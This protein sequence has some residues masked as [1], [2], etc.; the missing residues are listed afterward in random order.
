MKITSLYFVTKYSVLK[1][2]WLI[3]VV[4]CMS[5]YFVDVGGLLARQHKLKDQY[6]ILCLT[7]IL[8]LSD[9]GVPTINKGVRQGCSLLPTLFNICI[10]DMFETWE[11]MA[12]PGIQMTNTS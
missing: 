10:D 3:V 12:Y 8:G 7:I 1:S 6:I 9:K 5:K 11:T 2:V 4:K